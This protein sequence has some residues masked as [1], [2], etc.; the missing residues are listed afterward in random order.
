MWSDLIGSAGPKVGEGNP[1]RH[2]HV[3]LVPR[4]RLELNLDEAVA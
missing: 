3:E 1:G 2:V 4:V